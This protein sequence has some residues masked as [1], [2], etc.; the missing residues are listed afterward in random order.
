MLLLVSNTYK[1]C[2]VSC[3]SRLRREIPVTPEC[4]EEIYS[5]IEAGVSIFRSSG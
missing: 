1:A 4:F 5:S 2:G 3:F